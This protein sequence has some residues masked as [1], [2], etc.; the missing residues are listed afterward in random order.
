MPL[1]KSGYSGKRENVSQPAK[2][3]HGVTT[4]TALEPGSSYLW[5][6]QGFD[7]LTHDRIS[8]DS[9]RFRGRV[10]FPYWFNAPALN[11]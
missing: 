3:G 9:R 5:R 10:E 4:A 8:A 1:V 11:G 6:V 2:I 7:P